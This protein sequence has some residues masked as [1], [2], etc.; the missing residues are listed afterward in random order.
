MPGSVTSLDQ[1]AELLNDAIGPIDKA[2]LDL[3]KALDFARSMGDQESAQVVDGFHREVDDLLTLA[4]DLRTRLQ[5][6]EL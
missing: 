1:V 5:H 6:A 2:R 3:A 4:A